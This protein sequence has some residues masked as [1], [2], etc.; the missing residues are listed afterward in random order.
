MQHNLPYST[1]IPVKTYKKQIC[2][3]SK[4]AYIGDNII[5]PISVVDKR[6][7]FNPPNL[8]F[9]IT[10]TSED[11]FY[12]IGTAP[13]I[14]DRRYLSTEIELSYTKF[15]FPGDV[16]QATV[17]LRQAILSLLS[18]RIDY[19]V[20]VPV[21]VAPTGASVDVLRKLVIQNVIINSS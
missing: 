9:V 2:Q 13:G 21:D 12:K 8:A 10:G 17:S 20:A 15:I 18:G 5:I 7:P 11:G 3:K 19:I 4:S 14:L 1:Y 6:S 16:P